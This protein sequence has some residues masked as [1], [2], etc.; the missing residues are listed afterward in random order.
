MFDLLY[1]FHVLGCYNENGPLIDRLPTMVPI[2]A[3]GQKFVSMFNCESPSGLRA[4][5]LI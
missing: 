5:T 3:M 4:G 2:K 1:W